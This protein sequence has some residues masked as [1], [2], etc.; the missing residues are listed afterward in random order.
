MSYIL[1]NIYYYI[2]YRESNSLFNSNHNLINEEKLIKII[3]QD[4]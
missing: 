4:T 1:Y 2:L 3:I